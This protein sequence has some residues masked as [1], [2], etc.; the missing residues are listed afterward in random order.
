MV[1]AAPEPTSPYFNEDT[2][3]LFGLPRE[4]AANAP[5]DLIDYMYPAHMYDR[6]WQGST[7]TKT[8][9]DHP[10]TPDRVRALS[11]FF[12]ER[13]VAYNAQT[14]EWRR[15]LE[16][17][18]IERL[19][20]NGFTED[21]ARAKVDSL[22]ERMEAG[23]TRDNR[24]NVT[25]EVGRGADALSAWEA[26]GVLQR[27]ANLPYIGPAN[28]PAGKPASPHTPESE[29][30][31]AADFNKMQK[32]T[33]A[34]KAALNRAVTGTKNVTN[35]R[36]QTEGEWLAYV[37]PHVRAKMRRYPDIKDVDGTFGDIVSDA[38]TLVGLAFPDLPREQTDMY[39]LHSIRP[40]SMDDTLML[41]FIGQ[42]Y[43]PE[44]AA[45]M[46]RGI[47]TT[48][49]LPPDEAV[50]FLTN[51]LRTD[52]PEQLPRVIARREKLIPIIEQNFNVST[53]HAKRA[54]MDLLSTPE[55]RSLGSTILLAN[56]YA[57]DANI[58]PGWAQ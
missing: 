19:T 10:N 36:Y 57:Q 32:Q 55:G 22:V 18:A 44:A 35:Q 53:E 17:R 43:T 47:A 25:N 20:M 48:F 56:K 15:P 11:T 42:T 4:D 13:P 40:H 50:A 29:A 33:D 5:R 23:T 14:G 39:A 38:K 37:G 58:N 34:A 45:L 1:A 7:P 30:T 6:V 26:L 9:Q 31:A 41:S 52:G 51:L 3:D 54:A 28:A 16:A 21:T 8:S 24:G 12:A 46:L 2:S 27:A 49:E